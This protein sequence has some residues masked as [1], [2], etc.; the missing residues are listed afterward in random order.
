MK[1]RKKKTLACGITLKP[2]H[3]RTRFSVYE[4]EVHEQNKKEGLPNMTLKRPL[5]A[6]C[7][8]IVAE[9]SDIGTPTELN[10]PQ[11]LSYQPSF[12]KA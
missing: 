1:R 9:Q 5:P 3:V 11:F 6:P 10:N 2:M 4:V 7:T 8:K 12:I